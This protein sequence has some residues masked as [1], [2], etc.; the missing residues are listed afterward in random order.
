MGGTRSGSARISGAARSAARDGQN[1]EDHL[2]FNGDQNAGPGPE[3]VLGNILPRASDSPG[4]ETAGTSQTT[5][6]ST[7][8]MCSTGTGT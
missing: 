1:L 2:L 6:F 4:R 8:T 7:G 5:F 3:V